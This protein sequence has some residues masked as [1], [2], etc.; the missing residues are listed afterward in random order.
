M[1]KE[2]LFALAETEHTAEF[3]NDGPTIPP[4]YRAAPFSDVCHFLGIAPAADED[5]GTCCAYVEAAAST[6][7]HR[8]GDRLEHIYIVASGVA[9]TVVQRAEEDFIAGFFLP[10]DMLGLDGVDG[11]AHPSAIIAVTDLLLLKVPY[12]VLRKY[13]KQYQT[14][15]KAMM[16]VFADRIAGTTAFMEVMARARSEVKVA[17]FLNSLAVR[18]GTSCEPAEHLDFRIPRRDIASYLGIA[19]ET[20]SRI[21][22]D[23][24]E[25]GMINL[26]RSKLTITDHVLLQGFVKAIPKG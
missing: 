12:P 18:L 26:T 16:R 9:K 22:H 7:V 1:N 3:G 10:G 13:C 2:K 21:L 24:C 17:Y 14:F 15:D 23:F 19:Y 25:L 5:V 11:L 20:L 4:R 6:F 8:C